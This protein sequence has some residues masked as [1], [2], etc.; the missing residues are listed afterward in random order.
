M[1]THHVQFY[2]TTGRCATI[3]AC[4]LIARMVTGRA[5]YL[6]KTIMG[7]ACASEARAKMVGRL[8]MLIAHATRRAAA[9]EG[10]KISLAEAFA[11]RPGQ[12][13]RLTE[14]TN[15][16]VERRRFLAS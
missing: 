10:M 1:A 14:A 2:L 11:G 16:P 5:A 4:S 8:A 12:V 6:E 3:S 13:D 9:R 7:A 15:V